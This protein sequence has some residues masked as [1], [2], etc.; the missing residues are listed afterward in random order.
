V[1]ATIKKLIWDNIWLW[2]ANI[3]NL[4][5]TQANQLI[6]NNK[7]GPKELANYGL[8]FQVI[9]II[10][11][12]QTQLLRLTAPSIA[13]VTQEGG[14]ASEILQYLYKYCA[15]TLALTLALVI[16]V[17]FLTPYFIH[18]FIGKDFSTAIPVLYILYIWSV[19]YG[20]ALINS[21]FLIGLRLQRLSFFS[22]CFFGLLS[23][24][25]AQVFVEKYKAMGAALSL[26]I[27]HLSSVLFQ[28]FIVYIRVKKLQN[29]STNRVHTLSKELNE[30]QE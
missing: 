27:S 20:A 11:L 10:R 1:F 2:F 4:L 24:V 21:Q 17:Y 5:M 19:F 29:Q 6:L 9:T 28:F 12:L 14:N 22:T 13:D 25:L 3:G 26:V 16:P 30:Y 18:Q 23:L 7:F 8:A 15:L